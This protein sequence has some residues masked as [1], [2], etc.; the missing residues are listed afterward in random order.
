M[1]NQ[2]KERY[3]KT[4]DMIHSDAVI[5][6]TPERSKKLRIH[7]ITRRLSYAVAGLAAI[8]CLSNGICLA[9]T[10][11][12]WVHKVFSTAMV[13]RSNAMQKT[14]PCLSVSNQPIKPMSP[15]KPED[16]ISP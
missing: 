4:F 3:K 9:A 15:R 16:C 1:N 11:S 13:R 12:T 10:G 7:T 2:N 14:L 8:F 6:I 5:N